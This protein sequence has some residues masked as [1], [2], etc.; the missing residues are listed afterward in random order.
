LAG[1]QRRLTNHFLC[2]NF[3]LLTPMYRDVFSPR[4]FRPLTAGALAASSAAGTA[5]A[6]TGATGAASTAG[7]ADGTAKLGSPIEAAAPAAAA[8]FPRALVGA[9]AAAAAPPSNAPPSA[10]PLT[11]ANRSGSAEL[12][13]SAGDAKWRGSGPL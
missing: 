11:P 5:A 12:C 8:A 3:V 4:G 13:V 10:L 2:A 1:L 9:T 7:A 6:A